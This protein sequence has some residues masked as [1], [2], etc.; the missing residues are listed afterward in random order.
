MA[1]EAIA[2]QEGRS[3]ETPSVPIAVFDFDGTVI[4]AQSGTQ[5]TKYLLLKHYIGPIIAFKVI[6]W[7]LRYTLHLPIDQDRVRLDRKSVV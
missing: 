7:G 2:A 3:G 1:Q 5:F 4:N 6:W